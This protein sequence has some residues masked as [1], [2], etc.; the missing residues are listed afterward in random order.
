M[1]NLLLVLILFLLFSFGGCNN[2][3]NDTKGYGNGIKQEVHVTEIEWCCTEW[4]QLQFPVDLK[5]D[6]GKEVKAIE[7]NQYATDVATAI[8]AKCHEQ[9]L[10]DDYTLVSIVHSKKDNIWRFEYSIDQ[11]ST[12]IDDLIDCGSLYV[13]IDGNE[14]ILIQAWIEE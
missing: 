5:I 14:G 1:N 2:V 3:S 4:D 13:A 9:G 11:R 8:L 7:T 12:H 10:F 6:L